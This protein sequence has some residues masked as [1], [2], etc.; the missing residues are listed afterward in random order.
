MTLVRKSGDSLHFNSTVNG[1]KSALRDRRLALELPVPSTPASFAQASHAF[2]PPMWDEHPAGSLTP[3]QLLE[4]PLLEVE[5]CT[6]EDCAPVLEMAT[7]GV[8]SEMAE[9]AVQLCRMIDGET[10][11]AVVVQVLLQ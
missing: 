9:A 11:A 5:P 8:D 4:L 3:N 10:D 7:S 1:I 6:A 2:G